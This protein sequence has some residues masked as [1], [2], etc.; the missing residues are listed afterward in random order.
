MSERLI[1]FDNV[2]TTF[3]DPLAIEIMVKALSSHVGNPSSH[4]HSAGIAAASILDSA[5]D[6]MA[7]FIGAKAESIIFT[8]GATE[9]NNLAISGFLKANPGYQLVISNI[10]HFS[11]LNQAARVK[12][13]GR[14]VSFL[15]VDQDG[16]VDSSEL[17]SIL[18]P[19]PALVSV[20]MAN[21]EIG[22]IQDIAVIGE[23]CRKY[24]VSEY[25]KQR[26]E[27][28]DLSITS[29]FGEEKQQQLGLADFM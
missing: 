11:I 28:L 19:G 20:S 25:T 24:K 21:P 4:V 10:E 7:S 15:T 12:R 14:K 13:E 1:Y 9:S 6:K 3:P 26:V 23:I 18:A 8:S 29:T 22:T 27:V 16:L 2:N 17:E 5:R